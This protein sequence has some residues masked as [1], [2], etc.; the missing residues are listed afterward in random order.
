MEPSIWSPIESMLTQ[1][2]LLLQALRDPSRPDH[3]LAF[4]TL[5]TEVASSDFVLHML[6]I[7][8]RGY[9]QSLVSIGLTSDLRQLSGLVL[10]NYSIL[11]FG[12]LSHPV[13]LLIETEILH[14]IVDTLPDIRKTSFIL[15]GKIA[16]SF[17]IS[18]WSQLFLTLI[19][20]LDSSNFLQ[21]DGAL[22]SIKLICED[23]CDKLVNVDG[24]LVAILIPK[25]L[26]M[27]KSEESL[28]RLHALDCMVALLAFLPVAT[29][30]IPMSIPL[31]IQ[32]LSAL[33]T[34]PSPRVN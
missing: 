15:M 26:H 4:T 8:S 13:Q 10:K 20:L 25:L 34:D 16:S 30:P 28:F 14:A 17:P 31:F 6:H 18:S 24:N 9:D 22:A 5:K 2:I 27:F 32:E 33:A 1:C 21:V 19:S 7:F 3:Q 11:H 12:K 23:A 29:A